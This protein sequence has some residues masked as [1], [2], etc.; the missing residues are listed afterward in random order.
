MSLRA[1]PYLCKEECLDDIWMAEHVMLIL[2]D[3]Y[4]R[5]GQS[6]TKDNVLTSMKT[7]N[8]LLEHDITMVETCVAIKI[9]S[10]GTVA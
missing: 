1:M 10:G 7:A 9:A 8:K 3:C 4:R 5:T 2:M 6:V